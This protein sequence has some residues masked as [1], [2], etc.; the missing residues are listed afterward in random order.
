MKKKFSGFTFEER[1]TQRGFTLIELLVTMT[2]MA[3]LMGI[4]LVSYQGARKSAR[5]GKRKTDLE[6][7]R[8]ALEMCRT[9]SGSYPIGNLSSGGTIICNTKTYLT[10]PADPLTDRIYSYTGT[11][12]TYTLCV[13]LEVSSGTVIGCG[14]C[15]LNCNYKTVNP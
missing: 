14:S 12:N 6:Q 5:D 2:I 4:A 1:K 13:T 10:I 9:D 7:I 8:S 15:T 11:A 3:M